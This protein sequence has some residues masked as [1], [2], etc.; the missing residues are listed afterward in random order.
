M[1]KSE[2]KNERIF[3][4][5]KEHGT[6][7]TFDAIRLYGATRL[8]AIIFNLREDGYDIETRME[9]SVDRY[10]NSCRYARY[11]YHGSCS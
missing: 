3:N 10:G 9:K 7:T 11:I 6:I 1:S 2:S 8:A 5:L 4:H